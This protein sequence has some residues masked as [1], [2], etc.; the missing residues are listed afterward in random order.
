MVCPHAHIDTK[1]HG[2]SDE[3]YHLQRTFYALAAGQPMC[4]RISVKIDGIQLSF[5]SL[6]SNA[7]RYYSMNECEKETPNHVEIVP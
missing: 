7:F 5:S 2:S 6:V 4:A 1:I 3:M